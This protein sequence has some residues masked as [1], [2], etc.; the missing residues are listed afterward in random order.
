MSKRT[1]IIT[2]FALVLLGMG[3]IFT[4]SRVEKPPA[5]SSEVRRAPEQ[6]S[7]APAVV[8]T[9]GEKE[10]RSRE[11]NAH[12]FCAPG[13]TVYLTQAQQEYKLGERGPDSPDVQAAQRNGAKAKVT[14]RVVDSRGNPVPDADV[15]VAFF[16]RGP[17]SVDGKTDENG[18]FTAKHMSESDVHF[19]AS[20]E[21]Y[22]RT[23]RNYWFYREGK[24]CAKDG[25]WIPWNPT[26]EVVMKEKRNPIM[27]KER[28]IALK[29]PESS[30]R[31]G[32][33][34]M[35]GD[36][37]KP[38][39]NG[40]VA[41]VWIE[42][43]SNPKTTDREATWEHR[44]TFDFQNEDDGLAVYVEDSFSQMR[45]PYEAP[46]KGYAQRMSFVR[47]GKGDTVQL[48]NRLKDNEGVI[49]R[50]RTR[51]QDGQLQGGFYGVTVGKFQF[52]AGPYVRAN[53]QYL[54]NLNEGDRNIEAERA[55][56]KGF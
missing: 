11:G 29:M 51:K 43:V 41:D 13:S 3:L 1:I 7:A 36:W 34:F 24:P 19:H 49:F 37:V 20:K 55:I 28:S 12:P 9:G 45:T 48:D 42:S 53:F 56:S 35:E 25:R 23:Y 22:Y 44:L 2:A 39:G 30:G 52:P 50:V 5:L 8:T 31:F 6:T 21:G 17:Y 16:H 54:I 10:T 27:M 33:D 4:R 14:L 38:H 46:D 40:V 32:F 18:F 26:L 47:T 15:K